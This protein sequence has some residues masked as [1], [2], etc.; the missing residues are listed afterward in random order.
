LSGVS[1]DHLYSILDG[2]TN[3]IDPKLLS[4]PA[5]CRIMVHNGPNGNNSKNSK[6]SITLE[7]LKIRINIWTKK[8]GGCIQC[9][10]ESVPIRDSVLQTDATR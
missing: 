1:R 9:F 10:P 2:Y 7:E 5:N 8:Y 6:S 3:K 4:H